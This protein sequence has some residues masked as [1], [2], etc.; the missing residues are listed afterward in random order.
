MGYKMGF[1]EEDR[2]IFKCLIFFV[3]VGLEKLK[4]ESSKFFLNKETRQV[5]ERQILLEFDQS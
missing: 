1:I 3:L 4:F 5:L 2:Y